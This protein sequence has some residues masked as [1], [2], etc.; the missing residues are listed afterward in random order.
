M[1]RENAPLWQAA[2]SGSL[3]AWR[4]PLEHQGGWAV[5]GGAVG[6]CGGSLAPKGAGLASWWLRKGQRVRRRVGHHLLHIPP[7]TRTLGGLAFSLGLHLTLGGR[8]RKGIL[9]KP[10]VFWVEPQDEG[11]P[12]PSPPGEVLDA[13]RAEA[14]VLGA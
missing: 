1:Y 14:V 6:R 4:L 5:W 12:A 8:G 7:L 10:G 2:L 3:W 11:L 13:L 9:Q